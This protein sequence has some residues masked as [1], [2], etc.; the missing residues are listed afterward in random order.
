MVLS[1]A[2][3]Q[4][5]RRP[6]FRGVTLIE[7]MIVIVVLGI[8][9]AIAYPNYRNFAARSKRSEARAALLQ[10]ATNQERFYLSQS[11]YTDDLTNLG[12]PNDPFVTETGSYRIRIVPGANSSGYRAEA[13]YLLGGGEETKCNLFTIDSDGIKGS[14]PYTDC[15]TRT[16]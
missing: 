1:K 3:P 5:A 11:T 14:D 15:W 13:S 16:R 9:A 10:I 12:F 7:L 2:S 6:G 4:W 8:L